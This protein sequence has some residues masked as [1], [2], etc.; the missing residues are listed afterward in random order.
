[1]V[2]E[3]DAIDLFCGVGG[4][5]RGLLDAGVNVRGGVDCDPACHYPYEKNNKTQF[6]GAKIEDLHADELRSLYRNNKIRLLA[7]CAPC[8]PF[9]KYSQGKDSSKDGKWGLLYHF[10]ELVEAL[11]PELITM[12]NV[13]EVVKHSVFD[14]FVSA[15]KKLGYFIDFR[16][17]D[18]RH[19]GLAQSRLRLVLVA[20]KLGEI[21]VPEPTHSESS[22]VTVKDTIGGL[23]PLKAGE[24]HP[25][26]RLHICSRLSDLNLK[27]IRQSK[28][29][30][31]WRDW[32]PELV[33]TCHQS[34]KGKTYSSVYGRMSW[35][36]PAPTMTTQCFGFGNG[37]FG[38][39][40]Q[41]RAISLRE[42]AIF[43]SFPP[44]YE[45]V[46]PDSPVYI[47]VVGRLIGNAVPVKLGQA[48]GK[49]L[50]E[51]V[52]HINNQI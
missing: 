45:F 38:H 47:K 7:G 10:S 1:M 28:P 18:C 33:A 44:D 16:V 21:K 2:H 32:D 37:R 22:F 52:R 4:L 51:H 5:T 39:P 9:S 24:Q 3:I 15:L 50:I 42:A 19:Y 26:D 11:K 14:D 36:E 31:S 8:Q 23:P 20:S 25:H 6:I 48:I 27:R 46:H 17:L 41:D 43:Q 29:G 30:G 12:E 35:E 40:A 34:E 49:T 13:P